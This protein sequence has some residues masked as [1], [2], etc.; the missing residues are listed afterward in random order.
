MKT[1]RRI[2]L[3]APAGDLEK[4]KMAVLYGADAVYLAAPDFGLRAYSNNFTPEE[5]LEGIALAHAS[6]VK[7]YLALNILAH[8]ADLVILRQSVRSLLATSPDAVIVSDPGVFCLIREEAPAMKI[9]ISTQASVTNSRTCRFWHDLGASRIVL[10]R[11]LT[12]GEICEI[13]QDV[14]AR[15]ELEGF[16]HGA[17]CMAYSGRCLLSNFYSGRDSNRGRCSQPC[18]W[19][20]EVIEEKRPD[21]PLVVTGDKRGSYLFNSRDLCLIEHIPALAQAGLDS[22]KI[23]GRV[24]SAFYVATVVKA[25]RE[26]LDC[27]MTDPESYVFQPEWLADLRKTV[28]REFDTGFYFVPPQEDPKIFT[29]DANQREAAVVGIIRGYLPES[30]LALVEQRNKIEAGDYLELVLPTGRHVDFQAAGLLDLERRPLAATPHPQMYYY[31]ML[32]VT[33]SPGAFLRRLGDKD[34]PA[35]GSRL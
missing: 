29:A 20:Y 18:R 31:L 26:A 4:L 34:R 21:Q 6:N 16:V 17:M 23:E 33:A 28:H 12:L 22:F 30:G 10:A 24:K 9:H 3:L 7:A 14:P 25:Y 35:K 5:M 8:Q 11:E 1:R 32:P 27:Y 2:E 19:K 13:R 15:L